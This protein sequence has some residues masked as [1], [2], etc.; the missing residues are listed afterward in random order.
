MLARRGLM[1]GLLVVGLGAAPALAVEN[2]IPQGHVYAPG[3][4]M[5][6]PLNSPEDR[7]NLGADLLQSEIYAQ[8]HQRQL[9]NSELNRFI[10]EQHP[11]PTDNSLDY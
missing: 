8:Q 5:L 10:N 3:E 11:D 7:V 2:F 9:F 6:P 1:L 4:E